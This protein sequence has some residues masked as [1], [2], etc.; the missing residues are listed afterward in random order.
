MS[1]GLSDGTAGGTVFL[2]RPHKRAALRLQLTEVAV[3][4]RKNR[5]LFGKGLVGKFAA[6]G[7]LLAVSACDKNEK[8]ETSTAAQPVTPAAS[9]TTASAPKKTVTLPEITIPDPP[10]ALGKPKIPANNPVTSAKVL[11]G[12]KLFFDKRLSVDG[13]RA[14]ISC[15]M[16]EDGTGGHDPTAIGAKDV[17]IPRHAPTLWNV[18]Y[19]PKLTW[20]GR[21]DSLEANAMGAI[22]GPSLG[23]PKD[24][25]QK[26]ADEIGALAEYEPLFDA[27]F[28]G[29]GATPTTITQALASYERTLYCGDTAY[30]KFAAGDTSALTDVQKKGWDVFSNAAKGN[31]ASCHTPPFF[32]DAYMAEQGAFHNI[33]TA[34]RDKKPEE[35]D[36]GRQ[37]YSNADS[38]LGAFKTPSLRNITKTAPYFH[39]GSGK[40]LE[41]AVRF[42]AGG[43]F[44]NKNLDPK[45][46]DK[47]LSNDDIKSLL[48]FFESLE[49]KG[50]L[51]PPKL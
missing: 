31:C 51:E 49:C 15:H 44:K 30:D 17:K 45:L 24:A 1:H 42:M 10:A 20:D 40:T 46:V 2:S 6:L 3:V 21:Q 48:A 5:I 39:D 12:N 28:P 23:V 41:E 22:T 26:K 34:F 32:S 4:L 36:P 25:F 18:G 50:T 27:A 33:G 29:E 35:V 7:V 47:K 8:S 13:S 43:G 16:N 37:K 11:L 9:A 19:L 38:D 14:C